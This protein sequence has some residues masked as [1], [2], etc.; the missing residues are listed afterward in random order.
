MFRLFYILVFLISKSW[1]A[2][3]KHHIPYCFLQNYTIEAAW[4]GANTCFISLR[5]QNIC[6]I[7]T[8][9]PKNAKIYTVLL[10]T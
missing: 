7:C 10:Q 5:M 4:G 8:F 9:S 2:F 1:V 6:D 3:K